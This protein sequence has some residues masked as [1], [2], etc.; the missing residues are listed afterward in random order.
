MSLFNPQDEREELDEMSELK[1]LKGPEKSVEELTESFR[2]DYFGVIGKG[3][4]EK[5]MRIDIDSRVKMDL[6]PP[7]LRIRFKEA[8]KKRT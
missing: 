4:M 3:S 1:D 8:K 6:K 7:Y 5:Y 2:D